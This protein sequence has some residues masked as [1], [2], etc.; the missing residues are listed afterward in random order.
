MWGRIGTRRRRRWGRGRCLSR[1]TGLAPDRA[2]RGRLAEHEAARQGRRRRIRY[3]V[4]VSCGVT[5]PEVSRSRARR[6]TRPERLREPLDDLLRLAPLLNEPELRV[7][8]TTTSTPGSK[9]PGATAKRS[10]PRPAGLRR[11]LWESLNRDPQ[12]IVT[13]SHRKPAVVTPRLIHSAL[14]SFS[15]RHTASLNAARSSRDTDGS[16]P[17]PSPEGKAEVAELHPFCRFCSDVNA[18]LP[19]LQ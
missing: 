3:V 1:L 2:E 11:M 6:Q 16:R 8:L 12:C 13:H 10:I 17:A 14:R 5:G 18:H 19:L 4:R 7:L 15:C 9:C